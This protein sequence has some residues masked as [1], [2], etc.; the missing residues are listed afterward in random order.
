MP[1]EFRIL[2]TVQ[3]LATRG[4][5]AEKTRNTEIRVAGNPAETEEVEGIEGIEG[6]A[7]VQQVG[8]GLTKRKTLGERNGRRSIG[9][10]PQPQ[11]H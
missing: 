3:T 6:T 11:S 2:R 10:P 7:E 1:T 4:L 5:E 8:L 9:L